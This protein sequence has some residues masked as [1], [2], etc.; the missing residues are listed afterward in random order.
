MYTQKYSP[1]LETK[2]RLSRMSVLADSSTT[3]VN[4]VGPQNPEPY[5]DPHETREQVVV[6]VSLA[7]V[8]VGFCRRS[9]TSMKLRPQGQGARIS[10]EVTISDF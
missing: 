5:S 8:S 9:S 6:S 7:P 10:L 4:E 3:G 2:V 1:E